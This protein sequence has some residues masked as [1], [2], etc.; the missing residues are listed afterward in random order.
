MTKTKQHISQKTISKSISKFAV[1]MIT[2]KYK[3]IFFLIS[4]GS[5]ADTG[6][7]LNIL[8]RIFWPSVFMY[9]IIL[10]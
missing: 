2:D 3:Y 10:S 8:V 5:G 6:Q 7:R 4:G 9:A 1:K